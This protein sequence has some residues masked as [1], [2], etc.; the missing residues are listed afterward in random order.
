MILNKTF[1]TLIAGEIFVLM[2]ESYKIQT[3]DERLQEFNDE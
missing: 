3:L 2:G 1:K